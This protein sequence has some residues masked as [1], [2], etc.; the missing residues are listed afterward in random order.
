[1]IVSCVELRI[2]NNV[3]QFYGLESERTIVIQL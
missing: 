3:D 2:Y 1:M